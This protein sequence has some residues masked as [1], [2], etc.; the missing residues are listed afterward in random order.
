MDQYYIKSKILVKTRKPV[1]LIISF[2]ILWVD[3]LGDTNQDK[4]VNIINS[5][6]TKELLVLKQIAISIKKVKTS[7]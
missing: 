7:S 6:S 5:F 1:K 3:T 2:K 4:Y